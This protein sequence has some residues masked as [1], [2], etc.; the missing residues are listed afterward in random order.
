MAGSDWDENPYAS[1]R[2]LDEGFVQPEV[3]DADVFLIEPSLRVRDG[4]D[5]LLGMLQ[6]GTWGCGFLAA[7]ALFLS[8]PLF[9]AFW[10]LEPALAALFAAV[11]VCLYFVCDVVMCVLM[12]CFMVSRLSIDGAG[13][14]FK[15]SLGQ[16]R[17]LRWSDIQSIRPAPRREVFLQGWLRPWPTREPTR[18]MSAYG[19]YRIEWTGGFLFFPPKDPA[20]FQRAVGKFAPNVLRSAE[21]P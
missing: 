15:R 11:W 4:I 6:V 13:V 7:S 18:T 3:V 20:L 2:S 21:V 14:A 10:S 17:F 19:H 1:P 16:P 8:V 5:V 9:L 12:L